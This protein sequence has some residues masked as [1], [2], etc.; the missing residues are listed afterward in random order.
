MNM[1]DKDANVIYNLFSEFHYADDLGVIKSKLTEYVTTIR[2][3]ERREVAMTIGS[4]LRRYGP[5]I[6]K[7]DLM[8]RFQELFREPEAAANETRE[9][10]QDGSQT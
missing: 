3:E 8:T 10:R 6:R 2:Q 5:N 9:D 1:K 4:E 7:V